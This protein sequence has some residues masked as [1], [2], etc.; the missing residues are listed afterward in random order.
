MHLHYLR[1]R[2]CPDIAQKSTD[3][4]NRY[5]SCLLS[6]ISRL[7]WSSYFRDELPLPSL[8]IA[9]YTSRGVYGDFSCGISSNI[10]S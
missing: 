1:S 2:K 10:Y 9:I 6:G 5:F 3:E 4:D 7:P 8:P